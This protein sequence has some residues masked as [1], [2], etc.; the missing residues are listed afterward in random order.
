MTGS[1]ETNPFPPKKVDKFI[2]RILK[3]RRFL[4]TTHANPDGDGL[5]S[6]MAMHFYLKKVG[7]ESHVINPGPTPA[8]FRAVDPRG[9]IRVFHLGAKLPKV[10]EIFIFDTNDVRMLGPMA[11]P[12]Q[13]LGAPIAF[14]DHHVPEAVKL[15]E[16][17]IDEQY[18]ATGELVFTLLRGLRADIDEEMARA[19]Y[20]AIVTDT[21]SFRFKRTSPRTH[22]VAA[23]LLQRGVLPERV[24]RDVYS[25][26]S[27]AKVK[28]LGYLLDNLHTTPDGRIAWMTV[29]KA[30]RDKYGATV[31]D[32]E[33][34][35]NQL[36]YVQGVDIAMLFREEDDGKIK[37][38]LRGMGEI[39]VVGLAKEFGGGGH[40]HA[41]GMRVSAPLDE[42]VRKVR[43]G[44]ERLLA[45]FGSTEE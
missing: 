18:A 38:S 29:P 3:A 14:I 27:L 15:D 20:V 34:Y 11:A 2:E 9:E 5:G 8:K 17:L 45:A 4:L 44:A 12:V 7:K 16:H 41:A 19:L 43:A 22:Q 6:Q 25:R 37:V 42:V 23:E 30:L 31:E 21:G 35:V 13:A 10:D 24:F 36:G 28:L 1:T 33:S 26:D 39:A 40:R 32:T